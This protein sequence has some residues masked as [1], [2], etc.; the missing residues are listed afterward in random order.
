MFYKIIWWLWKL[1]LLKTVELIVQVNAIVQSWCLEVFVEIMV[2]E[3]HS[4]C[5]E[6]P[7]IH[8]WVNVYL[9]MHWMTRRTDAFSSDLPEAS[10]H[11]G[12]EAHWLGAPLET[13]VIDLGSAFDCC[14]K[15]YNYFLFS[16]QTAFTLCIFFLI[17]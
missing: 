2:L 12:S 16:W 13:W 1:V 14:L 6:H 7:F 9:R 11:C 4:M 5:P 3:T 8:P 17:H 10:Q 15:V